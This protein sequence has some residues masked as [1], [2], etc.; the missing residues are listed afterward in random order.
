VNPTTTGR[1]RVLRPRHDSGELILVDRDDFEPTLVTLDGVGDVA[2][3]LGDGLRSGYLVDAELAWS[4]GTARLV[5][6]QVKEWT[7]FA[8]GDRVTNI[9]EDALDTWAE[10]QQQGLGVNSRVTFS[11]DGIPNGA[12]YTFAEQPGEQDIFAEFRE[13]RRPVDP[14]LDRLDSPPPY[15]VFILRPGTHEF[16]LVYVVLNKES[17]LADTVRDTYD[18]PRPTEPLRE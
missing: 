17:I 12:L 16:I 11:N 1:F 2:P 5:E 6:C 18:C 8:F 3:E 15:E 13:G 14:L 4:D 10:A 7:L 9:F